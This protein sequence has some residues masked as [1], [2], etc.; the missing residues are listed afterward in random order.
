[1]ER[2]ICALFGVCRTL[3]TGR[4]PTTFTVSQG[5]RLIR[6][7][8]KNIAC[9]LVPCVIHVAALCDV[10]L[11]G[12][13]PTFGDHSDIMAVRHTGMALLSSHSVQE[14]HDLALASEIAT[15]LCSVPFIH[16][17]DVIQTAPRRKIAAA[18][19]EHM[20]TVAKLLQPEFEKFRAR[21]LNPNHITS[22][23]TAQSPDIHVQNEA[24]A[25]AY[26]PAVPEAV[27]L[28]MKWIEKLTGRKYD[29]FQY[30]GHPQATEV[31]VVM[32]CG[33]QVV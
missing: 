14:T 13:L 10:P 3:V 15:F 1:M 27:R 23:G 30:V 5:L 29:L 26:H 2:E 17:F 16:F 18:G 20:K 9:E 7:N 32:G 8:L 25:N 24:V 33:A 4:R 31:I 28:A 21:A 6:L 12:A 19:E 11:A 22:P